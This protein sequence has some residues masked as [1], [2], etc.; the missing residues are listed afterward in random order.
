MVDI[1]KEE[2]ENPSIRCIFQDPAFKPSDKEFLKGLGYEVVED[3]E[4]FESVS[5]ESLV[6]YLARCVD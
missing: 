6:V 1:L 5:A 3:P 2:Q 4:A